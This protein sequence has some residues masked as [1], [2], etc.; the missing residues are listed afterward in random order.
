MAPGPSANAAASMLRIH[1]NFMVEEKGCKNLKVLH[2]RWHSKQREGIGA[3]AW[4]WAMV[5]I[6]GADHV[7]QHG[8]DKTGIDRQTTLAQWVLIESNG[9][10]EVVTL[11]SGGVLVSETAEE[12]AMYIKE[13][14]SVVQRRLNCCVKNWE[15][16][17]TVWCHCGKEAC[18]YKIRIAT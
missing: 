2:K 13:T 1:A 4:I 16:S 10:K 6:A 12:A 17:L 8:S 7:L 18:V 3:E 5:Q 11:E 9:E 14:W 15:V